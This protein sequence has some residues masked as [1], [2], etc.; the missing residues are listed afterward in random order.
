[1][2]AQ[3]GLPNNS[4]SMEY[5]AGG[6]LQLASSAAGNDKQ[7]YV[8]TGN[9]K[10]TADIPTPN[11][12]G[13]VYNLASSYTGSLAIGSQTLTVSGGSNVTS[14]TAG[15]TFGPTPLSGSPT[16]NIMNPVNGGTT[17][18]TLAQSLV[19]ATR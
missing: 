1:M 3:Y 4:T 7:N 10:M 16:F 6:E 9:A 8:V 5:L 2:T 17:L 12:A 14:G 11:G 18:L 19:T 15:F 13:Y